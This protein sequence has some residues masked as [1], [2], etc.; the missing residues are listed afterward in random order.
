MVV[1]PY[2]Y[3][4]LKFTSY[5]VKLLRTYQCKIFI[6]FLFCFILLLHY[7]NEVFTSEEPPSGCIVNKPLLVLLLLLLLLLLFIIIIMFDSREIVLLLFSQRVNILK[8]LIHLRSQRM[9]LVANFGQYRFV[10]AALIHFLKNSR[11][12]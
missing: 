2:A 1:D 5:N 7:S 12:I 6:L 3:T 10:Y 9:L 8:S 4:D 11:L